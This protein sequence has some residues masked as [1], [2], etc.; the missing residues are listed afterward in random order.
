MQENNS[1]HVKR[2][3]ET[4]ALFVQGI[5]YDGEKREKEGALMKQ[6]RRQR[7]GGEDK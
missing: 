1:L 5:A 4:A 7:E 2:S 3:G 6:K